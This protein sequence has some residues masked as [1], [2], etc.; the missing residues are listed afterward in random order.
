MFPGNVWVWAQRNNHVPLLFANKNDECPESSFFCCLWLE[1]MHW[2]GGIYMDIKISIF[3]QHGGNCNLSPLIPGVPEHGY[4]HTSCFGTCRLA[5]AA[6]SSILN[7]F[8]VSWFQKELIVSPSASHQWNQLALKRLPCSLPNRIL[9]ISG[10]ALEY[11][12]TGFQILVQVGISP[13]L[14]QRG[15]GNS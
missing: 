10:D 9:L 15:G 8:F 13:V 11:V 1:W 4:I 2:A 6:F 14:K 7:D 5:L 3:I 12:G